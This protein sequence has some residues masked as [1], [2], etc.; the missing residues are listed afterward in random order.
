MAAV[1]RRQYKGAAASTTTTNSLTSVDTSVTLT[2]TTGWPST[3]AVPFYVVID[4]GTSSEEKCSVTISGSTLTLTRAQDDTTAVAHSSGATIYPVF[5]ADEADEA[6]ALASVMTTRGDI[7]KMDTGPT[8][9]RL[10]I[11]SSGAVLYSDGTDPAWASLSTAG[12]APVA[13]PTF[14]GT[15]AAPTAANGTSTTQL[16]TTAYV[17][18]NGSQQTVSTKTASYTLVAAD[19]NTKVVMNSA[20]ATAITVNTS[21]F[22]AGDTLTLLNIGAGVCTV[23]A[24]TATVSTTGSLALAQNGGGTLYFTSAGV[25]VFQANGLAVALIPVVPTSV[26]VG[27]GSASVASNGTVTFTGCSSI[28]VNG[29]FTTSFTSYNIIY[30]AI[31]I[32]GTASIKVRLRASGTDNSSGNYANASSRVPFATGALANFTN[33]ATGTEFYIGDNDTD[34]KTGY[35]ITICNPMTAD[36]TNATFQG[37]SQTYRFEGGMNMTVTTAYDGI[38]F[39][40]N[41]YT[42]TGTILIAGYNQ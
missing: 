35:K 1:T 33:S 37:T 22:T 20:S 2:A 42:I 24:G 28:S 17:Y 5:S 11:G 30:N 10:A 13:S 34:G 29:C 21:L 41:G 23:T 19:R 6:N 36:K 26:A 32:G 25:S 7:I 40:P 9:A 39:I 38:S 27:S 8:V 31:T 4:P 16:A 12:I 3:A 15:P 14:T 18:A